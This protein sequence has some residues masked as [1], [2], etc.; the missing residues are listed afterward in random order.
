MTDELDTP[1][2][3]GKRKPGPRGTTVD[4]MALNLPKKTV[5]AMAVIQE[6]TGWNKTEVI[7]RSVQLCAYVL[8]NQQKG[9]GVYVRTR[10]RGD[11]ERIM[12]MG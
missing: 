9:G 2:E 1:E 12:F 4:R 8:E 10:E 11:L 6:I 3:G 7:N 5:T